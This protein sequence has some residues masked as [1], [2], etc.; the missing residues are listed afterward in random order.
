MAKTEEEELRGIAKLLA[1]LAKWRP[2]II[3]GLLVA[4]VVLSVA[5]WRTYGPKLIAPQS[6]NYEVSLERI[7][8]NA[9]PTW[10]KADIPGEVFHDAGWHEQPLSILEEDVAVRVA[11]AFEQHTWISKVTRVEKRS[12]AT[13]EIDLEYR[14]PVAMVEV[15]YDGQ[16]G[17]LPVDTVGVLLPPHDFTAEEAITYP[18]ITVDYSGPR[19]SIGTPWGDDRVIGGAKIA[20]LLVDHWDAL[21][22]YRI[23]AVSSSQPTTIRPITYQLQ[24][25]NGKAIE[26]GHAPANESAGETPGKEKVVKLLRYVQQHGKL[27]DDADSPPLDLRGNHEISSRP[28]AEPK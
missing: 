17:L 8:L 6:Q 11:Q 24:T 26:W 10:I 28:S 21:G 1:S 22:V 19:G 12:P 5:L 3:P 27:S 15:D 18:R 7:Q 4:A 2:L 20:S 25:R 14:R 9:P 16:G 23:V 13:L